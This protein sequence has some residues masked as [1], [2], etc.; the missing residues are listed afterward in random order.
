[1]RVLIPLI[2]FTTF[3]S[4]SISTGCS[5]TGSNN[6]AEDTLVTTHKIPDTLKVATLYSPL[7]FFLYREDTMGYDYTLVNEFAKSKNIKLDITVASSLEKAVSLL[8]SGLIDLIAYEVPVTSSFKTKVYPCGP[9]IFTSQVLVQRIE[10]GKKLITD[11]TELVGE[12]VWVEANSKYQ[13][14]IEN[15]N[16]E[17]GGGIN[18]H[19]IERDT[20]VDEDIIELVARQEIP[21][22]IVDSD[23]ARINKTYYNNIDVSLDVSFGQRSSWG[24]SPTNAWLGDS[25]SVWFATEGTQRDNEMLLKRYF[26]LS[27]YGPAFNLYTSLTKGRV[28]QYDDLFKKHAARIGWDWRILASQGYVESQFNNHLVSW[29]GARGIMQIMPSTARAFGVNP[30]TL[31]DPEVSISL[32]ADVLQS[33]DKIMSR[34]IEDPVERQKFVIACY[35]SGAAHIIDA[36]TLARKYGKNPDKWESNVEFALLMK[37]DARY[38]N[39]PDVKYGYFRGKQTTEYVK[40]VYEFYDRIQKHVHK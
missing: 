14:R 16:Q 33:T 30:E 25:I 29:A 5:C 15:L 13:H 19:Q 18:I 6:S 37:G 27:K 1:M 35:N 40:H 20:I 8:D 3:L 36:I 2:L 23:V 22:S 32:A 10:P 28:S 9:E 12:D 34:Y 39:D 38:Y 4:V 24:V 26:E 17:L 31:T 21:L 11:V 7:S